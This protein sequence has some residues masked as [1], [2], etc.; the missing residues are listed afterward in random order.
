MDE[1]IKKDL[2]QQTVE[3][4]ET[5]GNDSNNKKL[6]INNLL[7]FII[8]ILIIMSG[9]QVFQL[10]SISNAL[11]NGSLKLNTQ[12]Q[13]STVGLPSQVGGCG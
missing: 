2:P 3:T 13:G 5:T 12:T 7:L 8:A 9:V 10:Q 6:D 11:S 4:I 1:K